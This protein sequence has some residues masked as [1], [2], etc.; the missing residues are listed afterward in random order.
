[1][2]QIY[3]YHHCNEVVGVVVKWADLRRQQAQSQAGLQ[4]TISPGSPPNT[5]VGKY[6]ERRSLEKLASASSWRIKK[7]LNFYFDLKV[8][9]CPN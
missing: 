9:T 3:R 7:A 6:S 8:R 5:L 2:S 1:M 4:L